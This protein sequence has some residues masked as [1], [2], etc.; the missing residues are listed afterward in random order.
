MIKLFRTRHGLVVLVDD[1]AHYLLSN[2]Q[3]VDLLQEDSPAVVIRR[4]IGAGDVMRSDKPDEDSLLPPIDHQEVWASGVTYRRSCNARLEESAHGG[5]LL[6]NTDTRRMFTSCPTRSDS[7][8]RVELLDEH[9]VA[10]P[11]WSD[12]KE[13]HEYVG[14]TIAVASLAT[15]ACVSHRCVF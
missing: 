11:S 2:T 10:M 9:G 15:D 12:K 5:G 4:M 13:V 8:I 3:L 14:S 7:C 6:F 1:I